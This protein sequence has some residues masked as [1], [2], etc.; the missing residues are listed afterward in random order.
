MSKDYYNTLGVTKTA[1]QDEIKKAFRR[2]AHEFHPDKKTGDEAKFKEVN[3]AYQ[4]L[5]NEKKRSQYDQ[6]GS[7]FQNGQA[8][9]AG[10]GGFS[11]AEGFNI[12]MDDLGDMFGGIG[13]IFGFGG[14]RGQQ[15]SGPRRGND[16]QME[17][18][19]DFMDAVFGTEKELSFRKH[20][21]C[22]RCK[23]NLAEPGSKIEKCSRC[24]GLGRIRQA[25][26]T[27]LGAMQVE[28]VCPN[29]QG[30]GKTYAQKC[31]KCGGAGVNLE[32]VNLKVKIPAG[33]NSGETIRLT[34]QGETGQ[35]GG[36]EGDLYL[37]VH[38]KDHKE[39]ERDGYDVRSKKIISFEAAS[40]GDKVEV[41]T[42]EGG[43]KLKIPAGTQAG[44]T[45]KI[46]GKGISR[47][48][49]GGKGDH[50]VKV[51]VAVP[52]SLNR[53]QKDLIKELGL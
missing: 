32:N 33:I 53:K 5:G 27:I 13:D 1:T 43:V 42:V 49:G 35:K 9:G 38:V 24:S 37:R 41:E 44:T 11:G 10:F 48:R 51:N 34:G 18:Q 7:T 28:T 52:K 50:F 36:G 12:N 31:T 19:V 45:F 14:G 25:Q 30:E 20:V 46:K 39:F 22:D 17:V 4:V 26:R 47:L 6:F 23:G 2:K 3:E 16:M 40:L 8:G 29:C 15:S 21:K